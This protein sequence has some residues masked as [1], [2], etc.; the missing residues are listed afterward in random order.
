MFDLLSIALMQNF[1]TYFFNDKVYFALQSNGL[2]LDHKNRLFELQP[3]YNYFGNQINFCLLL[4]VG[5]GGGRSLILGGY[6]N[7]KSPSFRSLEAEDGYVISTV[8][9][10]FKC[11]PDCKTAK[12]PINC[13]KIH[14]STCYFVLRDCALIFSKAV[15]N[16]TKFVDFFV[17]LNRYHGKAT[18]CGQ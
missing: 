18:C 10:S 8:F 7:R 14:L 12:K 11:K 17:F 13:F 6:A 1:C 4:G 16:Y 3:C 2:Y 9:L 15:N 5:W